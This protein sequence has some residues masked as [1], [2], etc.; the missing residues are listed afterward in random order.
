MAVGRG[1]GRPLSTTSLIFDSL[2][3]EV[4]YFKQVTG[5]GNE[6]SATFSGMS[7]EV[8]QPA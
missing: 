4:V 8:D 7:S 2:S 5:S 3:S 1:A 6:F